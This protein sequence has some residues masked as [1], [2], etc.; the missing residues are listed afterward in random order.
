MSSPEVRTTALE[1]DR[2]HW[3]SLL[4]NCWTSIVIC[5]LCVPVCV[6]RIDTERD[7]RNVQL[8]MGRLLGNVL[9]FYLIFLSLFI[10]C[11]FVF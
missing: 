6:S 7:T 9:S 1:L 11:I 3:H 2:I 5:A 4:V 8:A 10:W